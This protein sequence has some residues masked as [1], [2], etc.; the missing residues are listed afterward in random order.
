MSYKLTHEAA[1][2]IESLLFHGML[3]FG[4]E[5]AINYHQRL[6]QMFELIAQFPEISRE[7]IELSPPC[8]IHPFSSHIIIYTV[9]KHGD[10][11]IVRV[12]HQHEDWI[13]DYS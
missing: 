1:Q 11:V 3:N 4:I 8:R 2:D 6:F 12:R 7:R 5:L 13:Q 9:D 10:I